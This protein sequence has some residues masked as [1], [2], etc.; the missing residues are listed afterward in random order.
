MFL[1]DTEAHR[2]LEL[3]NYLYSFFK[4]Y[5]VKNMALENKSS[6]AAYRSPR[7]DVRYAIIGFNVLI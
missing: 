2:D 6:S 3:Q 7:R 1:Y 4:N 5:R